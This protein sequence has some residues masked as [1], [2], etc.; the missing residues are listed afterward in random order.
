MG[1]LRPIGSEKLE[2]IDK[3]KRMI[4]ISQYN[5][6][7]PQPINEVSS[8][9]Y[10]KTLADGNTYHIVKEKNGYVIKKGLYE[11]TADYIEPMKNRRFFSSYS[12]A[13][14]RL[15]LITKEVN[16]L[17]GYNENLSLFNEND[18]V[19]YYL[20]QEQ[21]EQAPAPAPA[22]KQPAPAPAPAPAPTQPAPAPAPMEE[23]MDDTEEPMDDMEEPMDDMEEPMDDMEQGGD[24]EPEV[25]TYKTIQKLVGRLGQKTREFLS[26]EENQL[27]S[28]QVKYIVNSILSALPLDSLEEEDREE[29]ITKF[30]GGEDDMGGGEDDMEEPMDDMDFEGMD[31]EGDVPPAPQQ[32]ETAES[33]HH[34]KMGSRNLRDR[35]DKMKEVI[36][37]VFS[38]SKVDKVLGKYFGKP[39]SK[40]DKSIKHL[41]E[42]YVQEKRVS[43]IINENSNVKLVGK[44]K[45]GEILL[46][47][48]NKLITIDS[49]GYII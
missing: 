44:N 35:N 5:L 41:S 6:N 24:G 33:Y 34:R 2:G 15:N 21:N 30:E 16:L 10:K 49:K 18:Q 12:Q 29:I 9:E 45:N 28:N 37:N 47:K 3:I 1:K 20:K 39:S 17:E 19:K 32:P 36:E 8:N 48:E 4:E 43:K 40:L 46:I 7:V 26:D 31:E 22:P 27:D 23:P 11:S 14:K 42:S 38:E 13:L 25:V